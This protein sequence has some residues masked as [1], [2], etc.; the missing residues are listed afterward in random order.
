M[1]LE[2]QQKKVYSF[3]NSY[4][5]ICHNKV[6]ELHLFLHSSVEWKARENTRCSEERDKYCF[7]SYTEES[8]NMT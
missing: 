5:K 2:K 8:E 3:L 6:L 1:R 7:N 4:Y